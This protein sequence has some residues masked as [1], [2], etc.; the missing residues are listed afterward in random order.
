MQ[1]DFQVAFFYVTTSGWATRASA[2]KIADVSY[3]FSLVFTAINKK[4]PRP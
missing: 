3:S 2:G 4:G 1:V